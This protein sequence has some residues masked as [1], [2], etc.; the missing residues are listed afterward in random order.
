MYSKNKDAIMKSA[1]ALYSYPVQE[2]NTTKKIKSLASLLLFLLSAALI[3]S[4]CSILDK[5]EESSAPLRFAEESSEE[6]SSEESRTPESP[7]TEESKTEK[8]YASVEEFLS[9]PS[10]RTYV[11]SQIDLDRSQMSLFI[12]A[13]GNTLICTAQFLEHQPISDKAVFGELTSRLATACKADSGTYTSLMEYLRQNVA[14]DDIAVRVN[15]INSDTTMLY[16][17]VYDDCEK[18]ESIAAHILFGEDVPQIIADEAASLAS[19]DIAL[20]VYAMD[21]TV[22]YDY[23]YGESY[24]LSSDN[25]RETR[26]SLE[27]AF[28]DAADS[29]FAL[30]DEL[31][32][33][34]HGDDIRMLIIYRS[35]DSRIFFIAEF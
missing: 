22:V 15:Y 11:E 12:A 10:V 3:F 7:F 19:L 23:T 21:D 13:E 26:T 24:A 2:V 32:T 27:E 28:Q 8:T 17:C 29:H 31:R 30:L 9:D 4:G 33:Y 20:K 18:A 16:H 5:E 14:A 34:A 25:L 1:E 35:H 6:A